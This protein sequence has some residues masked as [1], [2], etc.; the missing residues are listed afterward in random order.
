MEGYRAT[1]ATRAYTRALVHCFQHPVAAASRRGRDGIKSHLQRKDMPIIRQD[2]VDHILDI[3]KIEEIVPEF[4]KLRKA[5]VNLT[6]LCPFHEDRNDGNFIVHPSGTASSPNTFRCFACDKKGGPVQFVMM[7]NNCDFPTAIRWLGAFYKVPVDDVPVDYTPPEPKPAPPPLPMMTLPMS[8]VLAREFTEHDP[9]CNWLRGLDL[10]GAQ[11]ARIEGVLKM[12]H[13]GHSRQGHTMWWQIDEN[14]VVRTGH[15]MKYN[16]DGH[17]VK[18]EQDSY[19]NAWV[20][21]MLFADKNLPKYDEKKMQYVTTYFGMHLM[22][23]YPKADVN[24][25]ESEKTA[26]IMSILYGEAHGI[27]M[28]CWG[29]SNLNAEKM[30]P[31]IEAKRRV[32]LFPDHDGIDEWEDKADLIDYERL[33][34][35][36]EPVKKWWIPEDGEKADIA[37]VVL[38]MMDADKRAY[39]TQRLNEIMNKSD[40]A[41]ALVEKFNLKPK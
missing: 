22:N 1:R 23:A 12:Y 21:R 29:K 36:T 10:D 38:R 17:R 37:D 2:I 25:V 40:A 11:K 33:T 16:P 32:I 14:G 39:K 13:V 41:K 28:A 8:M 7:A 3:A 4:V 26:V 35:N 24:I 6:G 15:M 20:H 34:V 9:F 31:L 5:G 19:A 30:K 18:K 27:W